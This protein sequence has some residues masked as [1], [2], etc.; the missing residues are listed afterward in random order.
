MT[1]NPQSTNAPE[2]ADTPTPET[3]VSNGEAAI[4]CPY[5]D[6]PFRTE[7]SRALHLG[8]THSTKWND[9][10][11]AAYEAA[12]DDEADDLFIFHLKVV[13]ALVGLYAFLVLAYM[14]VL[15]AG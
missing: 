12:E 7:R 4:R 11:R 1:S 8:E 14:V 10:E 15:G 3:H 2:P 5:C 9:D 13:A 6:R